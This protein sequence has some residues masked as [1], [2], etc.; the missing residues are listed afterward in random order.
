MNCSLKMVKMVNIM[1]WM[2][3]HNKTKQKTNYSI[4]TEKN[5]DENKG[6]TA[7]LSMMNLSNIKL[8]KESYIEHNV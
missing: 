8:S 6:S 1:L 2:F 7:T 5:R 4:F 3:Y